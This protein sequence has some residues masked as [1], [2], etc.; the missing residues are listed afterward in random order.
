MFR[1]ILAILMI[2]ALPVFTDEFVGI[3][4]DNF[5]SKNFKAIYSRFDSNLKKAISQETFEIQMTSVR[6]RLG[7]MQD[8]LT[9]DVGKLYFICETHLDTGTVNYKQNEEGELTAFYLQYQ[10]KSTFTYI[11]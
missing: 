8:Y 1:L 7:I 3:I 9:I 2:M 5:N 11:H 10:P 6:D 4:V